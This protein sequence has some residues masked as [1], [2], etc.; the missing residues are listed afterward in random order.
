MLKHGTRQQT[1]EGERDMTHE[2]DEPETK[3]AANDF[4]LSGGIV[5]KH[6]LCDVT[7]LPTK[8]THNIQEGEYTQPLELVDSGREDTQKDS[9]E[10]ENEDEVDGRPS[11]IS[12]CSD[13]DPPTRV[14]RKRG[15]LCPDIYLSGCVGDLATP[16]RVGRGQ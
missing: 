2:T 14:D 9:D 15:V 4:S 3:P 7:Q 1:G 13:V 6:S 8:N 16:V 12:Q 11:D 5:D 10:M